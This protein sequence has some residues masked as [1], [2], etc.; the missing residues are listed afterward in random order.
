[1]KQRQPEK[2]LDYNPLLL[3]YNDRLDGQVA[4]NSDTGGNQDTELC[5]DR[6]DATADNT[7]ELRAWS[8]RSTSCG[9]VEATWASITG[10]GSSRWGS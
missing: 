5:L 6:L 4:G 8:R 10:R 9:A 3:I 7:S 1:M 2:Y